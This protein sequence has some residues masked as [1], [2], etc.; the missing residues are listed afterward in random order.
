MLLSTPQAPAGA[1]ASADEAAVRQVIG[2]M[3]DA[4]ARADLEGFMARRSRVS[5]DYAARREATAQVLAGT[6]DIRLNS[7]AVE[8]V[9]VEGA[10]ARARVNAEL[11]GAD[12]STG[13]SSPQLG[14]LRRAVSL[15]REA[16]GWKVWGYVPV[17]QELG[18]ALASV[19]SAA[20]RQRL[21]RSE[22]EFV[23]LDLVRLLL[24]AAE[25]RAGG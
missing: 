9:V 16:S 4:Y 24:N 5:P 3:F 25:A 2:E 7:L 15:V 10:R 21:L 8:G 1:R 22:A 19:P 6:R 17:E 12:A 11:T 13:G 18:D 23:T 20:E 14:R